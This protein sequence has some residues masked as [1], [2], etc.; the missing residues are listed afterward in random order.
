MDEI[1]RQLKEIIVK[2]LRITDRSP[3]DLTDDQPLMDGDIEIDSVDV[4]QLILDIEKHFG[5][6]LVTGEFDRDSWKTINTLAAT[7]QSKLEENAL[8]S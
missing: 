7:V 2:G 3:A 5:I 1:K 8:R 4:L 6:K